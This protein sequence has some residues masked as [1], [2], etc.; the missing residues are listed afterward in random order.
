[1]GFRPAKVNRGMQRRT[2]HE[3]ARPGLEWKRT[4]DKVLI[5][6]VNVAVDRIVVACVRTRTC[7]CS[8]TTHKI[9]S[10]SLASTC[11][12][13][14]KGGS[15][16]ND[17]DGSERVSMIMCFEYWRMRGKRKHVGGSPP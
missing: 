5:P 15:R 11:S 8:S 2:R 17:P 10:S 7:A 9:L 12:T 16:K 3:E 1:M 6:L 13:H 4:L 14:G